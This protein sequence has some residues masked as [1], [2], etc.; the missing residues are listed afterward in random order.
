MVWTSNIVVARKK[1]GGVRVCVNLSDV[2]KALV[3]QRYPLPTMEEL[4]ERIAGSTVFSKLDIAW[5]YLQLELAEECRYVTAFV[6]HEGVFQ[7]R[8]LPFGLATGPS[9][10]QQVVRHMTD[11]LPGCVHILDDILCYGRDMVE[12]DTRLRDILD[13]LAKYDATLRVDKCVLGQSEMVTE[14]QPMVSDLCSRMSKLWN[15]CLRRPIGG[16]SLHSSAL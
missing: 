15:E 9:A 14:C 5:G 11:Q 10:F 1:C 8:S 3:P 13:R 4:T 12:H 2:N 16:S 6:S 7:W